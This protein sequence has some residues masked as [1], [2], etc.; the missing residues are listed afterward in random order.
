[1]A[2]S[3]RAEGRR[4]GTIGLTDARP[5]LIRPVRDRLASPVS[6]VL[7]CLAVVAPLAVLLGLLL[8]SA[9]LAWEVIGWWKEGSALMLRPDGGLV[10]WTPASW[11]QP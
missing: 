9:A 10:D 2:V 6:G 8:A 3:I 11:S 5:G 7:A 4:I 1:V